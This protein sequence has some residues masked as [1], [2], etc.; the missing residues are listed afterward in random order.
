MENI[1]NESERITSVIVNIQKELDDLQKNEVV[2][3]YF[4]LCE[5]EKE[6]RKQQKR[7]YTKLKNNEFAT[8]NHIWIT[9]RKEYDNCEGRLEK[10]CGCIKCGLDEVVLDR[11]RQYLPLEL[12][13]MY[14]FM[15]AYRY[16]YKGIRLGVVCDLE[17]AM[18]IYSKIKKNHPNIDDET[19][20]RYFEIALDHIRNIEVSEKRKVNRAKRL[21]LN[22][23]FNRWNGGDVCY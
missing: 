8:C 6:L 20:C 7:L 18:A 16:D 2:K 4:E 9:S 15:M 13:I 17:L 12:K 5:K 22:P 23:K 1:K 21:S 14:D 19:A 3:K 11:K 10:F